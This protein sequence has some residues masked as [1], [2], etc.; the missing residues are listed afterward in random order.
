MSGA[1]RP[2]ARP[3]SAESP[4]YASDITNVKVDNCANSSW[5]G[6][7]IERLVA[8]YSRVKPST[9]AEPYILKSD[10]R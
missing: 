2:R 4:G 3:T 7:P 5:F 6:R 1:S 10:V 9:F 8:S